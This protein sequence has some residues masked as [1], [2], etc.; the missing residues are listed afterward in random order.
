MTAVIGIDPGVTGAFAVHERGVLN[1]VVD[2]P[3]LEGRIDGASL[4]ALLRG[5]EDPVVYLENTQPMP[6]NGSIASYSLGLNTGIIVGV[7][8]SL[9]HPLV[10]VRPNEWK[11]KMAVTKLDK[12]GIRGIAREIYPQWADSFKRVMDHNRAEAVLISRYGVA[13]QLQEA[14][15]WKP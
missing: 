7:V 8:Q 14:N 3:V 4:A 13:Q 5:Y 9:S 6:K 1:A 10:R 12:N 11:R 2:L 15:A